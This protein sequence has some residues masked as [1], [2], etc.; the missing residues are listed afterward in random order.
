VSQ[1]R[2]FDWNGGLGLSLVCCPC[3]LVSRSNQ[4]FSAR[5]SGTV[6]RSGDQF[7]VHANGA[8]RNYYCAIPHVLQLCL[9]GKPE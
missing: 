2:D 8:Y 4:S 1:F 7:T 3:F 6:L 5:Y 9:Q